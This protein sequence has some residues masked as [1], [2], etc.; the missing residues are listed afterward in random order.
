[1]NF[2]FRVTVWAFNRYLEVI[3]SGRDK[4]LYREGFP[5]RSKQISKLFVQDGFLSVFSSLLVALP[6][7]TR[8]RTD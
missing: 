4:L 7:L 1:M 6:W 3:L 5:G 2:L 8:R